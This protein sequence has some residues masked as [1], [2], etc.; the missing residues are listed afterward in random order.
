[1]SA[2]PPS[3]LGR[4]EQAGHSSYVVSRSELRGEVDLFG[5]KNSVLKLL[6]AS[7]LSSDPIEIRSFPKTLLDVRVH[8]GMLERLG[9]T[10]E[11]EERSIS[12]KEPRKLKTELLWEGRSIRN[13][14]L[15][16]GALTARFGEAGVPLPGGCKLGDRKYDLHESVLRALGAEVW[17]EDGMLRTRAKSGLRGADIHLPLRSTGATENAILSGTLASGVTRV[18]NPHIRPEVLDLVAFLRQMGAQIRVF[19]Q[20]HIE[21]T[22]VK[23]LRGAS[24]EPIADNMEALTW[25]IGATITGG[26]VE[27]T[28]F[29]WSDLEVPLIF[30][31]ESGA[32][33]YR[34]GTRAIVRGGTPY[35]IEISTGPYPGINSDM[36]PLFAVYGALARGESRIVDLRFPGRYRYAEELAKLGVQYKVKDNLL[37]ITGGPPLKGAEV[38]AVDLRAG[39]A[40]VLA[41]LT[42]SGQTVIRDAWQ[43]ERGYEAFLEK[44]RRL[45][46]QA[47]HA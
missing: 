22:G 26:D 1:M 19:G 45:G 33:V 27:I 47:A 16:L 41:A 15:M 42:A 30:L 23:E 8:I 13:T 25:L 46:G 40:L 17:E 38:T 14:L 18:W 37:A 9:K 28:N 24:H 43:I 21:I 44:L 12:I 39:I 4:E 29:P 34:S 35:P 3:I 5:A 7:L 6:T 32:R 20:E 31:R 36:Q 10:C 11:L 2:T